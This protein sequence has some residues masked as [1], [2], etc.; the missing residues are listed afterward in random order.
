MNATLAVAAPRTIGGLPIRVVLGLGFAT[1]VWGSTYTAIR[2][3]F[4][5]VDPRWSIAYRF[6]IATATMYAIARRTGAPIAITRRELPVVAGIALSQFVL[7]TTLLYGATA[8]ITSGLV[9]MIFALLILPNAV[10]GWL[11]MGQR[12]GL[13]FMFGTLLAVI[14]TALLFEPQIGAL[15]ADRTRIA[16]GI[17]FATAGVLASSVGNLLQGSR[18]ANGMHWATVMLWS[19]ALATPINILL[20]LATVGLPAFDPRP[21]YWIATVYLGMCGSALSLPIY[22]V[23]IRHIGPARAAYSSILVPVVAMAFSTILE[24]YHWTTAAITG[25]ILAFAGLF[26]ALRARTGT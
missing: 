12:V 21:A 3:Q 6:A 25:S 19:M 1:L 26:F 9:A 10:L 18:R 14:G 23:A 22:L 8:Y 4:G 16:I 5:V 2:H 24:G 17:G 13:G 20:A 15:T 11:F 7:N